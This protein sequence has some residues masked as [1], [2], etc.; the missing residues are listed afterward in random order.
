ME[1]LV[2]KATKCTPRIVFDSEHASLEISGVSYPENT[3]AFYTPVFEWLNTFM[4]TP[5]IGKVNV[6]LEIEYFNSSSSK[7][8]LDFFDILDE[9]AGGGKKITVYWVYDSRN[10]QALQYGIEFKEDI[11][12]LDFHITCKDANE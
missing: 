9:A 11:N 5:K 10:Q 12:H 6:R 2:I 7:I 3:S 1:N 4:A 8:L